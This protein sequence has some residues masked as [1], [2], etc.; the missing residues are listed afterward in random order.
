[1]SDELVPLS[2]TEIQARLASELPHWYYENGWI[3]R[4]YRTGGW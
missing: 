2:E 4:K 3:R 1:M